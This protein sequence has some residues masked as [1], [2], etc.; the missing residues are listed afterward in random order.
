MRILVGIDTYGLIGGSERYAISVSQELSARGHQV[1]VLSGASQEPSTP[2]LPVTVLPEYSLERGSRADLAPLVRAIRSFRPE[3]LYLLSAR[4]RASLRAMTRLTPEFPV[5]RYIQDHTLFCPGLTKMHFGGEICSK[6]FGMICLRHY[7]LEKGCTAFR[8]ELHRSSLD[9]F[10]GMWKWKRDLDLARRASALYVASAYMRAE[11]LKVGMPEERVQLV[12]MFTHSCSAH[13]PSTPPDEATRAFVQGSTAPVVLAS[14]RLALP[15]KGVDV[16]LEALARLRSP[17]RAVVAGTGPDESW[18]KDKA[19]ELGLGGRI[20][21]A[22][23]QAAPAMEWLYARAQVV[24]FPSIW[25]EPFGLV[26]IEAMAH[27]K[28]VVAFDVG[29]VRDWL[30]PGVT[31][32]LHP[33]RDADGFAGSLQRLLDE[34]ALATSMGRAGRRKAE[35][36]FSPE[37]HVRHLED[38]FRRLVASS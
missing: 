30:E 15:T 14:A 33:R 3:V 1:A 10:G 31:G 12:P 11:L 8:R 6:P 2:D 37:R 7:F 17:Y 5:I 23:W 4:G 29:G 38:S 20:H 9:A 35:E 27:S 22:G 21:F 16:L 13:A 32:F 34:P 19:R 36:L 18:L 28:P 26:G 25:D 24:A